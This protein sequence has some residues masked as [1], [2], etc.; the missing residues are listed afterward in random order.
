MH[1]AY[2]LRTVENEQRLLSWRSF[3]ISSEAT[4]FSAN[5]AMIHLILYRFIRANTRFWF[6]IVARILLQKRNN[7]LMLH[8]LQFYFYIC[9][10][11]LVTTQAISSTGDEDFLEAPYKSTFIALHVF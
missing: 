11:W 1:P 5:I 10:F 6:S 3:N 9:L 8:T 4:I 7:F 2:L